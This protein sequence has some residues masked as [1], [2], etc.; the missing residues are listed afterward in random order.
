MTYIK[1]ILFV[2]KFYYTFYTFKL[3]Q[4]FVYKHLNFINQFFLKK[5]LDFIN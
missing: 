5:Y 2:Y 3:M 1:K 4:L